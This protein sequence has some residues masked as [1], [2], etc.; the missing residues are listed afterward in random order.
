MVGAP[1]AV[2]RIPRHAPIVAVAVDERALVVV[3]HV[4]VVALVL[5]DVVQLGRPRKVEILIIIAQ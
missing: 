2:Q 5:L 3:R 1:D 4:V